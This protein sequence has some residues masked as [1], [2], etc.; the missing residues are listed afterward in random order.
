MNN[1]KKLYKFAYGGKAKANA[2]VEDDEVAETPFGNLMKFN[3]AT[4]EQGGIDANLPQGTKIFSDRISVDGQTMAERKLERE[5]RIKKVS[6]FL[7]KNPTDMIKKNSFKRIKEFNDMQEASDMEVQQMANR[8]FNPSKRKF[9]MGGILGGMD[10]NGLFAAMNANQDPL[11]TDD[12]LGQGTGIST[13]LSTEP[14]ANQSYLDMIAPNDG[15]DFPEVETNMGTAA[16]GNKSGVGFTPGDILGMSGNAIGS[17]APLMGTLLNRKTDTPNINPYRNYGNRGIETF[18]KSFNNLEATKG[19]QMQ[20]VTTRANASKNSIRNSSRSLNTQRA[21]ETILDA[22][23][24]EAMSNIENTNANSYNQLL[25]GK[26]QL[27]NT[28]DQ[29]FSQGEQYRDISDR[30]DKDAFQSN[31]GANIGTFAK[32]LQSQAASMNANKYQND[33][34]SLLNEM[35]KYGMIEQD[36]NGSFK[37]VNKKK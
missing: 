8:I 3:G 21:F 9:A 12:M 22:S 18:N 35:Y 24:N 30:Q 23:V 6:D 19:R 4:H 27:Q 15:G 10:W 5:R 16:T 31:I 33:M 1:T 36:N 25:S 14:V 20:G 29:L 7:Q 34:M 13:E 2:E 26:T 37:I 28:Q 11:T 17:I 32:G